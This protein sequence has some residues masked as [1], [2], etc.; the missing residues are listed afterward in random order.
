[1]SWGG[2]RREP[3]AGAEATRWGSVHLPET[4]GVPPPHRH[5]IK[6][7]LWAAWG[8]AGPLRPRQTQLLE[9]ESGSLR[10]SLAVPSPPY[11]PGMQSSPGDTDRSYPLGKDL[12]VRPPATASREK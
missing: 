12:I 11:R 1:M 10:V 8:Q 3:L 2:G 5:S 7:P 4:E 6:A 9:Q